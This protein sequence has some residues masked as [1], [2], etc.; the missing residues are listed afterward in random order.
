MNCVGFT[1]PEKGITREQLHSLQRVL[2]Q[3]WKQGYHEA[4]HGDCVGGDAQFDSLCKRMNFLITIHPPSDPKL[5]A[6]C[7]NS[8]KI[9]DPKPYLVRDKDIARESDILIACPRETCEIRRSGVWATVRYARQFNKPVVII[10]PD[11]SIKEEIN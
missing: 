1:G 10:W 4:R 7:I 11:G 8:H 9:L 2:F 6:Y 3:L 5:R